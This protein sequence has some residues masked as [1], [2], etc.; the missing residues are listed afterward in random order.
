MWKSASTDKDTGKSADIETEDT[1]LLG[2]KVDTLDEMRPIVLHGGSGASTGQQS[3]ATISKQPSPYGFFERPW[4][5]FTEMLFN[6]GPVQASLALDKRVLEKRAGTISIKES[7]A[8]EFAVENAIIRRQ[9]QQRISKRLIDPSKTQMTADELDKLQE[10]FEFFH[11]LAVELDRLEDELQAKADIE[12]QA[13]RA[14]SAEAT[15]LRQNASRKRRAAF[16]ARVTA[17]LTFMVTIVNVALVAWRGPDEPETL[18]FEALTTILASVAAN[19]ARKYGDK[20]SKSAS[21][22]EADGFQAL[23]PGLGS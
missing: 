6:D 17:V 7:Q 22:N 14:D 20:E 23:T 8:Q 18:F 4:R 12:N 3:S 11:E 1:K 13:F 10:L 16:I 9:F 19:Y 5:R 21:E 2:I 15:L